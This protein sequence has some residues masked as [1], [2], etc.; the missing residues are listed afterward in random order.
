MSKMARRVQRRI[1]VDNIKSISATVTGSATFRVLRDPNL[2]CKG[3]I[4]PRRGDRCRPDFALNMD[5]YVRF[6]SGTIESSLGGLSFSRLFHH[7]GRGTVASSLG[8]SIEDMC[9]QR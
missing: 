7:R 8:Y 3:N 6:K 5:R 2:R 1:E 9:D 4:P